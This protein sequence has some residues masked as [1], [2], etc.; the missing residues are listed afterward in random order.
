MKYE[1]VV[2]VLSSLAVVASLGLVAYELHQNNKEIIESNRLGRMQSA[3]DSVE[4]ATRARQMIIENSEVWSKA[5]AGEPLTDEE[6]MICE[7][8]SHTYFFTIGQLYEQAVHLNDDELIAS[9]L[10]L[11]NRLKKNYTPVKN[12][13]N[14]VRPEFISKGYR[15]QTESFDSAFA[16]SKLKG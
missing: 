5:I 12:Y 15:I 13:W 11:P 1:G 7:L 2:R 9:R 6:N 3:S 10:S 8:I 14:R 4:A 16:D